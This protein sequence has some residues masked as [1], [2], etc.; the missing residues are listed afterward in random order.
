[1]GLFNHLVLL[2]IFIY[3]SYKRLSA[4]DEQLSPVQR[5]QLFRGQQR[6]VLSIVPQGYRPWV[7]HTIYPLSL[8]NVVVLTYSKNHNNY[9][10]QR[11]GVDGG[12]NAAPCPKPG[13]M[14]KA[15]TMCRN[16]LQNTV[17]ACS[18][19]HQS[20]C[21]AILSTTQVFVRSATYAS[22][23]RLPA[24]SI[25]LIKNSVQKTVAVCSS[26]YRSTCALTLFCFRN[27]ARAPNNPDIDMSFGWCP[28]VFV[29]DL[30]GASLAINLPT[31]FEELDAFDII[32]AQVQE[33]TRIPPEQQRL[34]YG[35][36][37]Q[38]GKA[39]SFRYYNIGSGATLH[40]ALRLRGGMD[41]LKP[42][43]VSSGDPQHAVKRQKLFV[44]NKAAGDESKQLVNCGC[45]A[46][47]P[48]SQQGPEHLISLRQSQRH[49][50]DHGYY[51]DEEKKGEEVEE[52]DS[53]DE[54]DPEEE[55]GEEEVE[56][57]E[58]EPD[59][60]EDDSKILDLFFCHVAGETPEVKR[61]RESEMSTARAFVWGS[62]SCQILSSNSAV[63][64]LRDIQNFAR[65]Q[66]GKHAYI[67][68]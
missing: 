53:E 19:A 33:R 22:F 57:L 3:A 18:A 8:S 7:Q 55:E 63:T 20:I 1:M 56:K 64:C 5:V 50:K 54:S 11:E 44:E 14:T 45:K 60:N 6:G 49:G 4:R 58:E 12:V 38:L 27:V 62:I 41:P 34:C 61:N 23:F 10:G 66:Q 52:N 67:Y 46:C 9:I 43:R 24:R 36:G 39:K 51:F 16:R 29:K 40:L 59:A 31:Y 37:K 17:A 47:P 30:N 32:S 42:P 21:A 68:V 48:I 15:S 25:H 2:Y 35:F 13:C 26:V 65:T 28:Q